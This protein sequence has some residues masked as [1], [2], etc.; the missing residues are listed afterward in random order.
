MPGLA[1]RYAISIE[2][3]AFKILARKISNKLA[4]L[5]SLLLTE[6]EQDN[7]DTKNMIVQCLAIAWMIKFRALL[8]EEL[9][10]RIKEW[11]A[12][13]LGETFR[14]KFPGEFDKIFTV[15]IQY[16]AFCAVF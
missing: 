10:G 13:S 3:K 6:G 14:K 11:C 15:S 9:S 5:P 12:D 2:K 8:F 4:R 7:K 1:L 16:T